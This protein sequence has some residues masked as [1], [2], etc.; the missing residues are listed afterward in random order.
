M[1]RQM[2]ASVIRDHIAELP[3]GWRL[4]LSPDPESMPL[5]LRDKQFDAV[6][7]GPG[8]GIVYQV[9]AGRRAL[10][11]RAA[12]MSVQDLRNSIASLPGWRFELLLLP[13]PPPQLLDDGRIDQQ[14]ETVSKIRAV[15]TTA[16]FLLAFIALEWLLAILASRYRLDYYP[17][18]RRM[19]SELVQ[20]GR[21]DE[22]HLTQVRNFQAMRNAIV[23]AV[24][25]PRPTSGDLDILLN[26]VN[27]LRGE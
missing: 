1:D 7:I 4:E 3:E 14:M 5:V 23:H 13:E 8:G 20:T 6:A 27:S 21:L 18:A 12:M 2:I 9:V 22:L 10:R 16:A 11:D 17:N 25:G 24:D 15:D 19:A 26:L